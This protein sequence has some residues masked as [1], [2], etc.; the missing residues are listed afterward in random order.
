MI[1]R[2]GLVDA[3]ID[4]LLMRET[5]N[6]CLV[7]EAGVGKT[8]IAEGLAAKIAGRKDLYGRLGEAVIVELQV[9]SLLAGMGIGSALSAR[10][11]LD[12]LQRIGWTVPLL[13]VLVVAVLPSLIQLLL[14][15]HLAVRIALSAGLLAAGGAVLGL[16]FPLGMVR[17]GE[18]RKPWHWALNGAFGVLAAVMSLALSMAWGFATVGWIAAGCYGVAWVALRGAKTGH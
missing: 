15:V 10:V 3:V 13:L 12:R 14:P 1:G 17:F 11:G 2:E 8:A 6:P 18:R 7:G 4:V 9:A 16:W 5:N